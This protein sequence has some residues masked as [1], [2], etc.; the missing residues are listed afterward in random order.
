[1]KNKHSLIF[2]IL[3]TIGLGTSIPASFAIANRTTLN[4]RYLTDINTFLSYNGTYYC[5]YDDF[6]DVNSEAC[7]YED[8]E[9]KIKEFLKTLNWKECD[10]NDGT[11]FS[12]GLKRISIYT[13]SAEMTLYEDYNVSQITWKDGANYFANYRYYEFNSSNFDLLENIILEGDSKNV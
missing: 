3:I 12:I 5:S 8:S 9:N 13:S 1:M 11:N 4:G 10:K 2:L 7:F 6:L